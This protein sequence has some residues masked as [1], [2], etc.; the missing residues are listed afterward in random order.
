[1]RNIISIFILGFV[2]A[3]SAC[4]DPDLDPLRTDQIK[5]SALITL[6]G[7]AAD[8][9]NDADNYLGAV[10]KFSKKGDFAKENF[11]FD[12]DFIA[13]DITSLAKVEV[14]AKATEKGARVRVATVDGATFAVAKDAK[15]PTAKFSIPLKAILDATKADPSTMADDSYLYVECDITLKNGDVIAASDVT[16][17]S[18]FETAFFYPAHKLLY[19]VTK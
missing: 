15:Y 12:A 7:V 9:L 17:S 1:M 3:F 2:L 11:E 13:E 8:N 5:K 4:T 18:L 16:N 14:Y 19:L 6:R 10:D